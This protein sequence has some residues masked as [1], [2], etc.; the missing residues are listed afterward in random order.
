M[1]PLEDLPSSPQI[2]C[3]D[4]QCSEVSSAVGRSHYY[5]ESKYDSKTLR[6]DHYIHQPV[7]VYWSRVLYC[8][9][10]REE[11]GEQ[12]QIR[13]ESQWPVSP[14]TLGT[15]QR[16]DDDRHC[17]AS[18]HPARVLGSH[19]LQ[20]KLLAGGPLPSISLPGLLLLLLLLGVPVL[21]LPTPDQLRGGC[22]LP[23]QQ[24]V[25]QLWE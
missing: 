13:D 18:S 3:R 14:V 25:R 12:Y 21:L 16:Q 24:A 11:G 15:G 5:N 22:G 1:S 19:L 20:H 17:V 7:G 6:C 10:E 8:T 4:L 23:R 9:S 2:S